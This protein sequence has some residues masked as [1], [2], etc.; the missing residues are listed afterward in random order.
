MTNPICPNCKVK[1]KINFLELKTL[2]TERESKES[3][4]QRAGGLLIT[5]AREGIVG[6]SKYWYCKE[7]KNRWKQ[8]QEVI[9]RK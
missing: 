4:L 7:C 9:M 3:I 8:G 6:I 5:R 2:N 1:G